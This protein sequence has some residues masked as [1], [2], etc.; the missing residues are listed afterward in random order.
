MDGGDD[1]LIVEE[2]GWRDLSTQAACTGAKDGGASEHSGFQA[3]ICA[4]PNKRRINELECQS[5]E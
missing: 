3:R 1:L 5:H 4:T 2:A